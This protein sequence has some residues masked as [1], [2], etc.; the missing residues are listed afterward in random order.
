MLMAGCYWQ[1]S[2]GDTI[3]ISADNVV[4]HLDY[5]LEH[6]RRLLS[7]CASTLHNIVLCDHHLI[8]G[9][10]SWIISS[11]ADNRTLCANNQGA[12]PLDLKRKNGLVD[13]CWFSCFPLIW[14]PLL[15]FALNVLMLLVGVNGTPGSD[16]L[17]APLTN[18][19]S[20]MY[21]STL[22]THIHWLIPLSYF[23]FHCWLFKCLFPL[24]LSVVIMFPRQ[25]RF[26]LFLGF[27]QSAKNA[28]R[29]PF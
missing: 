7:L 23:A 25:G 29:V 10:L 4:S 8:E 12:C 20:D 3:C 11:A 21:T 2:R 9:G 6:V 13:F 1:T 22:Y 18:S 16:Y 27:T 14:S 17:S 24:S 19:I 28:P 26:N 15:L 5:L